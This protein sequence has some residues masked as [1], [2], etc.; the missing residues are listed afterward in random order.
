MCANIAPY[1]ADRLANRKLISQ[2]GKYI[3]I[4]VNTNLNVCENRDVK[5]LYALARKGVIKQFTG[6]SDPFELPSQADIVINGDD[7]IETNL[8]IILKHM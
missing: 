4:F 1:D 5:G 3:E 2:H 6:V 8:E 7:P